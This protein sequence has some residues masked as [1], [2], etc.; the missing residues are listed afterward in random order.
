MHLPAKKSLGQ[1]FLKSKEALRAIITAGNISA[2]DTI[3]EVG[4]GKGALTE[5]LLPLAGKVIAVEKDARLI[6]LL[7]ER[8]VEEI[9][10]GK[11]EIIEGDILEYRP[12]PQPLRAT[13]PNLG[14]DRGR[15]KIIA[16]IPYY[17][18]GVFLKKF[19]TENFKPSLMV[20]L[21]QKEVAERIVARDNK[22]SILSLSV[23]AYGTPKYVMTVKAKYFSPAPKVDSAII[24]IDN[25][26]QDFFKDISEEKFFQIVK[27]GF[28]HKR[29]M[30][31]GNLKS[32]LPPQPLLAQEGCPF[33]EQG[34]G[35]GKGC[36]E[37]T[38]KSLGIHEK[39]RAEDLSLEQWKKLAG[40]LQ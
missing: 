33:P 37:D 1:N 3:L 35:L 9:K 14:G 28:A 23:K 10:I 36:F 18:T 11:L 15:Y 22:E 4:P 26:S 31:A 20:L 17:I 32:L 8:F 16:N 29:K 39:A 25:I 21:L 5:L 40:K 24:L 13:P 6:P 27:A 38:F 2:A 30:L 12:D 34:K 19:L 7:Q